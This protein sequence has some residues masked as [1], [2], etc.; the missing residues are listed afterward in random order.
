LDDLTIN[1]DCP[2][3]G[4]QGYTIWPFK[5]PTAHITGLTASWRVPQPPANKTGDQVLFIFNGIESSSEK[6]VPGGIL[7]PV[8]QWTKA[9]WAVRSWYVRADFDPIAYPDVPDWSKSKSQGEIDNNDKG[10][11]YTKAVSVNPGQTITGTITGGI[12]V[13]GKYDYTCALA[14]DAVNQNDTMLRVTDIRELSYPVCAVESYGIRDD[15]KDEDY[16]SGSIT[17]TD[18]ALQI[19]GGSVNNIQWRDSK[20]KGGDYDPTS[21]MAGKKIEFKRT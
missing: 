13:N 14:V 18:I 1:V 7:Q 16:P 19:D 10:R 11:C 8:L 21:S 15:H 4:W 9:G 20:R 12:D 6:S 5:A 2:D 17:M 3:G